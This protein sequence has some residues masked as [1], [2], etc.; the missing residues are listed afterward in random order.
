MIV[1]FDL[2]VPNSNFAPP[3]Q[4]VGTYLDNGQYAQVLETTSRVFQ[5]GD[6]I[7]ATPV[8]NVGTA[9]AVTERPSFGI[10][11]PEPKEE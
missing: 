9:Q 3:L 10:S 2:T 6:G 5:E 1:F 11:G 8:A 4:V 7:A